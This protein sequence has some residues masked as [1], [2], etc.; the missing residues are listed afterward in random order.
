MFFVIL[1]WCLIAIGFVVRFLK[2]PKGKKL[3]TTLKP[4][5]GAIDSYQENLIGKTGAK[6]AFEQLSDQDP[7]RPQP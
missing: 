2:A 7:G 6:D 4:V 3:R 1:F 5:I